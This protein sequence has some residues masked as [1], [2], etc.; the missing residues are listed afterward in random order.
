LTWINAERPWHFWKE[1]DGSMA[2]NEELLA[3]I[4]SPNFPAIQ[5]NLA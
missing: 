4:V 1:A 2:A 5:I 3:E